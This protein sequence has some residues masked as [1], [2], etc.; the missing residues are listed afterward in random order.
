[1]KETSDDHAVFSFKKHDIVKSE[2]IYSLEVIRKNLINSEI[3]SVNIIYFDLQQIDAGTC[4]D[5]SLIL[6]KNILDKIHIFI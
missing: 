3:K 5:I 6:I 1:M 2:F 4:A